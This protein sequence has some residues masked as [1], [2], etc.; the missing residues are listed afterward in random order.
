MVVEGVGVEVALHMGDE[1]TING[2]GGGG[3][4]G[5]GKMA[6]PIVEVRGTPCPLLWFRACGV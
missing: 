4:L 2:G 3:G 6:K 5:G 1:G